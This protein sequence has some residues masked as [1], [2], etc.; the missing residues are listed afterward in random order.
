LKD[1]LVAAGIEVL[2]IGALYSRAREF[3]P[4]GSIAA[5]AGDDTPIVGVVEYRDGRVTDVIRRVTR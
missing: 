1:R 3:A 5:T 2:S 4:S